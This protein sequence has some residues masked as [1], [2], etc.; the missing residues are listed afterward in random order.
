MSYACS[1]FLVQLTI[2][3]ARKQEVRSLAVIEGK[4]FLKDFNGTWSNQS[5]LGTRYNINLRSRFLQSLELT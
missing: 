2:K 4:N 3:N 1:F 5:F